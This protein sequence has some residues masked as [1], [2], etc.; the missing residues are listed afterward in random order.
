M[1]DPALVSWCGVS[2]GFSDESDTAPWWELGEAEVEELRL[3]AGRHPHVRRLQVAVDDT[4]AVRGVER[5]CHLDAEVQER[6]ELDR[7][8]PDPLAKRLPLEELHRDEPLPLV[9]VDVVDGADA[10]VVEG[11]G[12]ARL[13]LEALEGLGFPG[14]ALGQ[15]LERHRAAEPGV[16]GLVDDAHPAAAE[17]LDHAVVGERLADHRKFSISISSYCAAAGVSPKR[18]HFSSGETVMDPWP[19]CSASFR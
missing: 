3:P 7:P 6:R 14:E 15:E 18:I 17:L 11:G 8:P 4:L 2:V 19:K 1:T 5:V 16:L 9:R 13:A 10:G 12:G